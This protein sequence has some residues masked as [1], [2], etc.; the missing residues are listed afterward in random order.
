MN[1]LKK[2]PSSLSNTIS[3]LLII[4]SIIPALIAL[5]LEQNH[6]FI[7]SATVTIA[8]AAYTLLSWREREA[9]KAELQGIKAAIAG[10]SDDSV[11]VT[12]IGDGVVA[13]QYLERIIEDATRVKNTHLMTTSGNLTYLQFSSENI[14]RVYQQMLRRKGVTWV[15]DLIELSCIVD[16]ANK[17]N[18]ERRR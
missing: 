5:I 12:C 2:I 14:K 11:D 16:S 4:A 3:L 7:P 17:P 6:Y 8:I 10:K 9:I 13:R 18:L 15:I 1:V